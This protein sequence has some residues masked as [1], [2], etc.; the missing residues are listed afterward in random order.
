MGWGPRPLCPQLG[1]GVGSEAPGDAL[2]SGVEHDYSEL[3]TKGP[4]SLQKPGLCG[5][6]SFLQDLS[7]GRGNALLRA[8]SLSS[9]KLPTCLQISSWAKVVGARCSQPHLLHLPLGPQEARPRQR[10]HLGRWR[11]GGWALLFGLASPCLCLCLC[12]LYQLGPAPFREEA[13]G[14]FYL[15]FLW[16]LPKAQAWP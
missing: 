9:G 5:G 16:C 8:V 2:F 10:L 15:C 11:A 7:G 12:P 3:G 14:S 6:G 1:S 4:S 13:S